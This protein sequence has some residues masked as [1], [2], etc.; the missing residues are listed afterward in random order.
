M[1]SVP[2]AARFARTGVFEHRLHKSAEAGVREVGAVHGFGQD[3]CGGEGA[4]QSDLGNAH[5][6][7]GISKRVCVIGER[8]EGEVNAVKFNLQ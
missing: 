1:V 4:V 8:R 2:S 5:F 7:N 6:F 3:G